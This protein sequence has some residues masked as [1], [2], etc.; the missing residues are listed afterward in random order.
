MNR[1]LVRQQP[2]FFLDWTGKAPQHCPGF[3]GGVL[4][5]LPQ[6]AITAGRRQVREYFDNGWTLTELLFS[7]LAGEEAFFRRPYHQLRHPMVFYYG[8]V[9]ALYVNKLRMA[10][11]LSAPI[12]E[13]FERL[14]ATGVDEMSWDDLY[15]GRQDVWPALHEVHEY[16]R[17]V[18]EAVADVIESTPLLPMPANHDNPQSSPLWALFMGFEHER[19]HLETSSVL[20]RELPLEYLR[21]PQH[22]PALPQPQTHAPRAA[23]ITVPE[24]HVQL[25]KPKAAPYFG[26]DNEYGIDVRRVRT[27]SAGSTLVTNAEF[28]EFVQDGGYA[29]PAL[30]SQ[31]GWGWK[32]FRK[33]CQPAFWV[34]HGPQARL[35]TIFEEVSMPWH[36][37]VIVN[38]HEAK[39]YCA[40]RTRAGSAATP[41]RL[42]TE[43]EHHA[44]RE[45]ALPEAN[46]N[47]RHGGECGV[48]AMP[49]TTRG[50]HGVFG[51]VWQ[52][53]EDHFHPLPGHAV[54]PYYHDFSTPCYDG[55]HQMIFGGSFISTGDMAMGWARFHF[56]PHFFQHAG[57]RIARSEDGN[58][59][60]SVRHVGA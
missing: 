31:D 40:W 1:P 11:L 23:L 21:T 9:A 41:Y 36:A 3:S 33:A 53:A 59:D 16:R 27:F 14:F 10:G 49:A 15:D 19:I 13:H 5:S 42:I 39:A 7:G 44:L 20:L 50:F 37:P 22:W 29:D 43:A 48:S 57:F 54:H 30:W 58:H 60:G 38:F 51:N 12:N 46:W 45:V 34:G 18:Y 17:Q 28:L 25:G 8:H 2:A 52:W 4:A 32:Q 35:R 56:R 24:C 6:L 55:R 26:W 47:L